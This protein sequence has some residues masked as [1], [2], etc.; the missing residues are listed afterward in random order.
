MKFQYPPVAKSIVLITLLLW[1][2]TAL[3]RPKI[4]PSM[5]K[6]R[7]E[8]AYTDNLAVW[9]KKPDHVDE[10]SYYWSIFHDMRQAERLLYWMK[11]GKF[12]RLTEEPVC[13]Q[14]APYYVLCHG[15]YEIV[16][17]HLLREQDWETPSLKFKITI[18]HPNT[19]EEIEF[20]LVEDYE[21]ILNPDLRHYEEFEKE[22][23]SINVGGFETRL[24]RWQRR[25]ASYHRCVG[26][27]KLPK[28]MLLEV[29]HQRCKT[30]D[31]IKALF[32]SF[33]YDRLLEKL[34]E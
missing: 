2:S 3:A 5:R 4:S 16:G 1:T 18:P 34:S 21:R 23:K 26:I 28:K 25:G 12:F 33:E 13:R 30:L 14:K 27:Q 17:R 19:F 22:D 24:I 31:P 9:K 29:Y 8:L 11:N 15:T 20:G 32:E 10:N 7:G 6:L